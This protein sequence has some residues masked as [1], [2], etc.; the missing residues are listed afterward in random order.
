MAFN[1]GSIIIEVSKRIN[2]PVGIS[3]T[4]MNGMV[5]GAINT[6]NNI[7]GQNPGSTN[8]QEKF[9]E[10]LVCLTA[11]SVADVNEGV[12]STS[13]GTTT[14]KGYKIGDFSFT[15]DNFNTGANSRISEAGK[16]W[17]KCADRE[18]RN[19]GYK[20]DFGKANG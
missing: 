4:N 1:I 7:T 17:D 16:G 11:A 3:G 8:I 6:V 14:G 15:G 20:M 9:N 12:V 5:V 2:I 19:L 13:T 18:L 10:V